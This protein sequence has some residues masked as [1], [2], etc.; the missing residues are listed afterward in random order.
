[1]L[2]FIYGYFF[3]FS[4]RRRH[5]R[6]VSDWSSDVC[7]SDLRSRRRLAFHGDTGSAALHGE[8]KKTDSANTPNSGQR[9]HSLN[10]LPVK[11]RALGQARVA[12]PAKNNSH[13]EH[14]VW[15]KSERNL[16]KTNKASQQQ[17]RANQNDDAKRH[18][19]DDEKTAGAYT[20]DG[21][22]FATSFFQFAGNFAARRLECRE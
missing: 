11:T 16:L 2:I 14:V 5:T 1:M 18:F 21:S 13:R 12:R 3:F 6:L 8:R 7:S 10:S 9:L 17:T 19:H 22:G 15:P 20:S 4:S